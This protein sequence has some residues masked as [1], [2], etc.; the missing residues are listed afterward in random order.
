MA[1]EK[2]RTRSV[3][4]FSHQAAPILSQSLRLAL[5]APATA[6][7]S[8]LQGAGNKMSTGRPGEMNSRVV[9]CEP[10]TYNMVLGRETA[11]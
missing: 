9:N 1:S 2:S 3:P 8:E 4:L 5:S 7:A 6:S 11:L 10:R